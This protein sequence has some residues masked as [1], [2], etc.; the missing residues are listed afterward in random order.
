VLLGLRARNLGYLIFGK[1][2]EFIPLE[3]VS[4]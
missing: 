3:F 4:L 1:L 2:V